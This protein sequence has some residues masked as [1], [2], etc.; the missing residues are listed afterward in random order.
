MNHLVSAFA[1]LAGFAL[2]SA[3]VY[4]AEPV[5]NIVLVHGAYADGSG[6]RQV[7]DIL[8]HEGYKVTVV[9]EPETSMADDVAATTRAIDQAGGSVVLVGH[10]YGGIVITQAGNAPSVKA[11]VYVAALAPD[12]HEDLAEVRGK[13]PAAT[14]NVIKSSDG[15][16]TLD[17]KT[18][19]EDFAADLP[20][21]DAD[22][23]ARSQVPVSEKALGTKVTEAAWRSKPSWYVVATE[24]HKINP[25]FERY[26]AKR[27]G[28]STVEIKGSHA[29]YVSQPQAVADLIKDAAE[30]AASN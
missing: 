4:S 21:A 7:S 1:A 30:G 28:S 18:F 3:P 23:M 9:Q 13:F 29:V 24:D 12:A 11:L 19:H 6:W 26:M 25:D 17:P 2:S 5:K 8:T 14:N 20:E 27:A 15:F 16:R 10:S 22:F